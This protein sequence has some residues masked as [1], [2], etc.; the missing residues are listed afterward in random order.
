MRSLLK[1]A[2]GCAMACLAFLS[3]SELSADTSYPY[4]SP[5]DKSETFN[6]DLGV[7]DFTDVPEWAS[8][9]VW[10]QIFP[11]RFQNADHRNDVGGGFPSWV[12]NA[13]P[14]LKGYRMKPLSW[15]LD[16]F[17]YTPEEERL[18][19]LLRQNRDKIQKTYNETFGN[20]NK[21]YD[22]DLDAEIYLARRYGGDLAGIREKI[23]Y[24]KELGINA[25]YLN[26]V[27]ESESLHRYDTT[28]YRHVD[29]DLGPMLTGDNGEPELYPEDK[30]IL[31]NLNLSDPDT[32]NY[33]YA[34]MEF[35]R[36]V[37]EFHRNGIKVV[38]DGVFNHQASN[39]AMMADIASKGLESRYFE[40]IDAVYNESQAFSKS[41]EQAYPC[42]ASR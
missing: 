22:R 40:W 30:E 16:W 41:I 13:V 3:S 38:I 10:Y 4:E 14:Q 27:F 35:M 37:N 24:L 31:D 21:V 33:T 12:V 25:I 36:L 20:T 6:Q 17:S 8:D 18:R 15:D 1:G 9:A 19:G 32:W 34:D 5:F 7:T 28:D 11:E 39:G 2:A 42:E 26:P 23:P 29:R